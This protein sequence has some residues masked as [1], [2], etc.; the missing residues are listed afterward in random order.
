MRPAFASPG[1]AGL[2][3]AEEG[4][5]TGR[6]EVSGARGLAFWDVVPPIHI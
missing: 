6:L 2:V 5:L 1:P 3:L 4:Q